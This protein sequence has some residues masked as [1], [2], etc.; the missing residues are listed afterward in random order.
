[1]YHHLDLYNRVWTRALGYLLFAILD[2]LEISQRE[3]CTDVEVTTWEVKQQRCVQ[4][5]INVFVAVLSSPS[6]DVDKREWR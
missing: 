4:N 1:M 2:I 5:E 6:R 3:K